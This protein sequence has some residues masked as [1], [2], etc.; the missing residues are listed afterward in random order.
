MDYRYLLYFE[1]DARVE[2]LERLAAMA[3][4][5]HDGPTTIVLPDRVIEVPFGTWGKPPQRITWDG[6]GSAWDFTTVLCFPPD[7]PLEDYLRYVN[8]S[9]IDG[10]TSG[11]DALRYDELGRLEVGFIDL[12]VYDTNS[13][14]GDELVCFRFGT[15]GTSMSM[16]FLDSESVRSSLLELLASCR[17]VYAVLDMEDYADLVWLRGER[18]DDRLPTADLSLAQIEALLSPAQAEK[19]P[20][21]EPAATRSGPLPL[22]FA[23]EQIFAEARHVTRT[24]RGGECGV[25]HWLLALH[26]DDDSPLAATWKQ[27]LA[28]GDVGQLLSEDQVRDR[29]ARRASQDART[30]VS[31]QD[32]AAVVAEVA[33][34]R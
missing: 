9:A 15:T 22:S 25:H 34:S 27:A 30:V 11:S 8:S 19:A 16:L 18:R 6:T 17:G 32:V 13:D 5:T 31:A 20:A 33:R 23:A 4:P 29:A 7:Q 21:G 28:S 12:S 24:T 1:R 26:P 10:S 14:T 2:A 3:A